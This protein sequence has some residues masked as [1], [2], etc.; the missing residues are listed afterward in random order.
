MNSAKNYIFSLLDSNIIENSSDIHNV[1]QLFF[2]T[3]KLNNL[4]IKNKLTPNDMHLKYH[5]HYSEGKRRKLI[6]RLLTLCPKY[7]SIKYNVDLSED[8][9]LIFNEC[10]ERLK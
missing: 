3:Q 8:L 5:M 2:A 6:S 7:K 4:R 1:K 9:N 10:G